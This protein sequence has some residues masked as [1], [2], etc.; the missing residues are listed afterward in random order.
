M[1]LKIITASERLEKRQGIKGQIWGRYGIGKTSLLH[2][3]EAESTLAI[4]LEAGMLSVQDWKGI[5]VPVRNWIDARDIA[6][7]VCGPNPALADDASY[8]QAHYDAMRARYPDFPLDQIKTVFIDST[9]NSGRYCFAWA[10]TQ[11][12]A[13]SE[14]TGK[15]DNRGA[16]GVLG[17]EMVA[18][19]N[20]WQ[21]A[22][23]LNV[24]L[25]GGLEERTDDF[26]RRTWTPL[27]EGSKAANELPYIVDQVITMA[28]VPAENGNYRALICQAPNPWGFP[29]K[30]RSG[31]LDMVE[32][33]HLGKLM[34]KIRG[35]K[36]EQAEPA[37]QKEGE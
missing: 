9:T 31:R 3:L 22:R 11:P 7:L 27:I 33:P 32:E 21:H 5:S 30:D 19:A 28:E 25:V 36:T 16:Y 14:K 24:W 4:D 12:Q 29:A 35:E 1:A 37:L 6:C 2:T 26:N 23:D 17:Q 10:K 20:Q 13:F 34:A 15:P 8:S 18:W